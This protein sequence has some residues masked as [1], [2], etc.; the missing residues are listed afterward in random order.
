MNSHIDSTVNPNIKV[1]M[2]NIEIHVI[3]RRDNLIFNIYMI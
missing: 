2:W 1:M 3:K